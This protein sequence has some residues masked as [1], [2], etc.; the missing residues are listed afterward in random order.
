M[1][2]RWQRLLFLWKLTGAEFAERSA[3]DL[4]DE[5]SPLLKEL[6][7]VHLLPALRQSVPEPGSFLLLPSQPRE[8]RREVLTGW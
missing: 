6:P 1:I 7:V 2:D 4:G 8:E 5:H 3:N